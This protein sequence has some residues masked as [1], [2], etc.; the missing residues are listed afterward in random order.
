[1]TIS[2]PV[3]VVVLCGA[4]CHATWNVFVKRGTDVALS[5]V[6]VCMGCGL[7]AAIALPFLPAPASASWPFIGVSCLAQLVYLALL[8]AA[9]KAGDLSQTYPIMRGAAPLLVALASGP[10]VG[11]SLSTGRWFGVG[12][13]SAGVAGMALARPATAVPS[14]I[15]PS[16]ALM[17]AAVIAI[18]TV[19]DGI[20]V[21]RSGAAVSYAFW[22]FVLTAVPVVLW[23]VT[24]RRRAFL[25]YAI[26]QWRIAVIGGTG[27]LLS[28]SLALWAMTRAPV[29]VVASLRETSI[30]FATAASVVVL[31]ERVAP[32]RIG[33]TALIVAGAAVIRSF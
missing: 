24:C 1:M 7:I 22:S 9:Y 13:I 15:A 8:T 25:T 16:L 26:A 33:S 30:L 2:T 6:L 14:G 21:R 3:I 18:F 20:G 23:A 11:E 12:L 10:L 31:K 27:T 28:Y 32:A 5:S 29:A 19:I 4:C 17:N